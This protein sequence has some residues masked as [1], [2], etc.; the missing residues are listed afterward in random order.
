MSERPLRIL[1]LCTG[2]S[3]RSILAEALTN[4]LG[5]GRLSAVSAGTKP[6]G[7][8]HPQALALLERGGIETSELRSESVEI[9]AGAGVRAIDLVVTLCDSAAAEP[10]PVLPGAPAT[11]HWGLADPAAVQGSEEERAEAFERTL[12]ELEARIRL[13]LALPAEEPRRRP[14]SP[15]SSAPST[16]AS[17]EQSG[18]RLSGPDETETG[19]TEFDEAGRAGRTAPG[20]RRWRRPVSTADDQGATLSQCAS[21]PCEKSSEKICPTHAAGRSN[22]GV[23]SAIELLA[24]WSALAPMPRLAKPRQ[25]SHW[26]SPS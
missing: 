19:E 9:Y 13:L 25:I 22:A 5:E 10:C 15:R 26:W 2:N 7:T 12:V 16:P 17:T 1:F 6:K 18:A 14:V 11:V 24:P 4:H 8:V 21:V 20:F 3:A 23:P